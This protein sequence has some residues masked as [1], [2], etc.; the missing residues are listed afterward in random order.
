MEKIIVKYGEMKLFGKIS[1][2]AI[3][4]TLDETAP[5]FKEYPISKKSYL[6]RE[7]NENDEQ[8]KY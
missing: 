5:M 1:I 3:M 7:E 8:H 6:Y 4:A 2:D